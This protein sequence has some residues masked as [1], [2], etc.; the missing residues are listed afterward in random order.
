[1]GPSIAG[2]LFIIA[3]RSFRGARNALYI[4]GGILVISLLIWVR[5]VFGLTM[6]S[7]I[8]LGILYI[9]AKAPAW[10]QGFS[11]QLL[12]VQACISN[13]R[14]ID[15]LF[16]RGATIDGKLMP[17]DSSVIAENLFL[18]FWFWGILMTG[19][20]LCLLFWSIRMAYKSR[21]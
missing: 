16:T 2:A 20:S 3:S 21:R 8:A 7:L 6:L 5:S 15:Y 13:Y 10:V 17:S 11:I 18:P 12:G 4:L 9:A 1:M 14:Q 19:A